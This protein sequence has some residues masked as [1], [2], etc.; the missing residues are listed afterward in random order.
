MADDVLDLVGGLDIGRQLYL[1][2]VE[3]DAGIVAERQ[4]L[5][6]EIV[7]ARLRL[8]VRL[9]RFGRRIENDLAGAPVDDELVVRL[10][11]LADVVEP[12]DRRNSLGTGEDRGVRRAPARVGDEGEHVFLVEPR[13]VGRGE[14][15]R[16]DDRLFPQIRELLAPLP[17]EVPDNAPADVANVL[18]ALL[19][20]LV[21]DVREGREHLVENEAQ[22]VRRV[23]L[24][25]PD[26]LDRLV[27][28]ELVVQYHQVRI[29]DLPVLL[30]DL[31]LER[32][33]ELL[34]LPF[35]L[36]ESLP[37]LVDLAVDLLRADMP[38]GDGQILDVDDERLAEGDSRGGRDAGERHLVLFGVG[39]VH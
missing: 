32:P 13:R 38:L 18:S 20:I 25:V 4:E 23:D 39:V 35:G 14:R 8:A 2:P 16:D 28:D 1:V 26:D 11:V 24:L 7:V 17:H 12:H 37:E 29:E 19:E 15:L 10:H 21:L 30:P 33:D 5:F 27:H 34:E 9:R 22:G 6:F 3:R 31:L 36:G